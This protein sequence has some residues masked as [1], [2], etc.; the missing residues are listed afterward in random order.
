VA[1]LAE[2]ALAIAPGFFSIETG[3]VDA[4][5]IETL[6][7]ALELLP[8]D[9]S[10]VRVRLLG[11]LAAALYWSTESRR[12]VEVVD[13]ATAIADRLGGREARAYALAAR[14]VGLWSP[15]SFE[16]R[17]AGL[18]DL[19]TLA[20]QSNDRD[21]RLMARVFR[22]ATFLERGDLGRVRKE[23]VSFEA[24]ARITRLPHVQWYVPM[25]RAMLEIT[26]GQ[27]ERARVQMAKMMEL[28]TPFEDANVVQTMLLQSAEITWQTGSPEQILS[29][30]ESHVLEHPALTEWECAHA[31]LLARSGHLVAARRLASHLLGV[32]DQEMMSRMNVG[33][34]LG[35]LAETCWLLDDEGLASR[36]DP[37]LVGM[38]T[39]VIVAGYGILCWG[40][41]SRG[42]GHVAATLGRW[43]EAEARYDDALH[44][45][46][47]IGA[48]AWFA[49]TN[50]AYARML[51]R[52]DGR[53]DRARASQMRDAGETIA[54]ELGLSRLDGE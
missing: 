30:V 52:R 2:T 17:E 53:G 25:Y 33:I 38:G 46:E 7:Q 8:S 54:R 43:D 41:M 20:D 40:S 24:V 42:L 26:K 27:F 13:E 37:L 50:G 10:V 47:Q 21:L 48:V 19:L 29:A 31:F 44:L 34:A 4:E 3:V 14:F 28:G 11:H 32:I 16:D 22:V 9:D 36:L 51:E 12:I 23:I 39:R 15:A 18:G 1:Q 35:A 5:L 45:E 6:E 49:R